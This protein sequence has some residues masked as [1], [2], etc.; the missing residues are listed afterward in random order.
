MF[1]VL[2]ISEC[3]IKL[4]SC[5]VKW[6]SDSYEDHIAI[7]YGSVLP[8]R[9]CT[10]QRT[11]ILQP[12]DQQLRHSHRLTRRHKDSSWNDVPVVPSVD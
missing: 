8:L 9:T 1:V 11:F 5:S 2:A 4:V 12:S 7:L 3:L 10:T 6:H